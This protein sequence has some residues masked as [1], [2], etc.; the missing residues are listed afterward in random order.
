[1]AYKHLVVTLVTLIAS[2]VFADGHSDVETHD[3][4]TEYY[5]FAFIGAAENQDPTFSGT[6]GGSPE[7]VETFFDDPALNIGF[8]IGRALPAL[9]EG[10]RGEVE[11]S[12]TDADIDNTNFSGNGP[13]QENANGGISTTRVL[14]SVYRD[15]SANC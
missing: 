6:I 15:R 12:Y 2:P 11:L 7:T 3:S 9:G 1:M 10:F 14:A 5:G 4:N 8:G 13:A